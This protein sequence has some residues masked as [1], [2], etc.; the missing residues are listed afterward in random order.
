M[1]KYLIRPAAAAPGVVASLDA[2][3]RAAA[4]RGVPGAAVAA[5]VPET[6]DRT[7]NQPFGWPLPCGTLPEAGGGRIAIVATDTFAASNPE[8]G[9][10]LEALPGDWSTG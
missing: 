9:T 3:N 7:G 6:W 2:R 1:P 5:L 10:A 4:Q 8:F